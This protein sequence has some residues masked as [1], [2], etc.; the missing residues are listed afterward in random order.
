M[1]EEKEEVKEEPAS[2]RAL[3]TKLR[4]QMA[5]SLDHGHS[6]APSGS[7]AAT[8]NA[9]RK[10][11]LLGILQQGWDLRSVCSLGCCSDHPPLLYHLLPHSSLRPCQ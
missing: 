7:G 2:H 11:N 10:V 8:H 4:K 9:R 6:E 5:T 3:E 1:Q